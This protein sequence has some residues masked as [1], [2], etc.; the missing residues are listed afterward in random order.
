M[1]DAGPGAVL[2][3]EAPD[4]E[5]EDCREMLVDEHRPTSVL[6]VL[7][8]GSVE[9]RARR[10]D[11]R[12]DGVDRAAFVA[13]DPAH[14]ADRSAVRRVG[15]PTDLTAVGVAIT[16]WVATRGPDED[17]VVCIE[18]FSAALQCVETERA[19]RFLHAVVSNCREHG[20]AIHV[21]L[22]GSTHDAHD[23]AT[24]RQLFDEQRRPGPPRADEDDEPSPVR[25]DGGIEDASRGD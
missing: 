5:G 22:T 14:S 24:L 11:E 10:L 3:L 18:G 12:A 25:V 20:A 15:A 2:V 1:T 16:E 17:P 6:S 19:F 8:T 9:E 13:V 4:R 7:Y 21:H 23:V